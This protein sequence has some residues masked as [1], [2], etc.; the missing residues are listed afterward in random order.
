LKEA[1]IK[2]RGMGLSIPLDGFSF[3]LS[4]ASRITFSEPGWAFW[5]WLLK[6]GHLLALCLPGAEGAT[7][8]RVRLWE[9]LPLLSSQPMV[10]EPSRT[11]PWYTMPP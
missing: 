6:D 4:Q 2:A 3:D 11:G 10:A 7:V 5:Q 8:P 1:Y 9:T